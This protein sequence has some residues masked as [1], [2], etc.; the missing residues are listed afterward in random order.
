MK[1]NIS[2]ELDGTEIIQDFIN[3]LSNKKVDTSVGAVKIVVTNKN[4]EPVEIA[5][6]KIK[7]V[8]NN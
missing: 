8:Y 1:L 2:A 4:G 7:L 5:P 3:A 6:E